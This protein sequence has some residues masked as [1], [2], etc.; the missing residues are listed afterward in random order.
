MTF[1]P[2]VARELR[3]ASRR[4]ST[5]WIRSGAALI[6]MLAGTWLF[7]VLRGDPPKD[8]AMVLFYVLTGGAVL[9]ALVSGP[10]STADSISEEIREGTLG[11]LFLTDLKG[12][13]VVLGKLVAGSLNAF[14]SVTAVLPMLAIPLLMGGGITLAEFGRMALVTVNT[15]FFSVTLAICVSALSRS[16]QTGISSILVAFFAAGLPACGALI[17]S[18]NK[19]TTVNP[20]FL[21]PSPGFSYYLAFDAPYKLSKEWFWGSVGFLHGCSWCCLILASLIAPRAWQERAGGQGALRWRQLWTQWTYGWGTERAVFRRQLLDINPIYWLIAR[22]RSKPATVWLLLAL[23]AIGWGAGWW[24]FRAEWLNEG[25]YVSTAVVLNLVLRYWFAA[26]AV[27]SLAEN[28]RAGALELLLS[29]PLRVEE[30]LRGQWLALKRQ[31]LGPLLVVLFV[32][33]LF[34]LTTVRHAVPDDDRLFWFALWA[35]GMLMLLADLVALYWVGM[36]LGLTARNKIRALSGSLIRILLLPWAGYGLVLLILVLRE[37]GPRSYQNGPAWTFFLG[38]WLGLG[39]GADLLFG[40]WARQ[41]LLSE[42]RTAAQQ[43]YESRAES[44]KKWLGTL[45]PRVSGLPEGNWDPKT[46]S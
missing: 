1:L 11:L 20:L 33:C 9:F 30:I 29:T 23:F 40:A 36:W 15:L 26:E 44:W 18:V 5:Y 17:A 38:L 42:F 22:V 7:L 2:I 32:E 4:R 12:Y 34:M 41:R 16:A 10:R 25:M 46:G 19:S 37:L 28:R 6:I 35:A 8:L 43:Q 21:A 14:Y 13:D 24:K 3:L 27:R 39:L 31:F 45:K